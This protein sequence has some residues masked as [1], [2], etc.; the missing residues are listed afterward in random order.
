M[1]RANS[2]IYSSGRS[3]EEEVLQLTRELINISKNLLLESD[4]IINNLLF[5]RIGGLYLMYG[6]Y[7]KQNKVYVLFIFSH[8]VNSSCIELMNFYTFQGQN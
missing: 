5:R 8:N 2:I 6:I 4:K 7:Y 3:S 1:H